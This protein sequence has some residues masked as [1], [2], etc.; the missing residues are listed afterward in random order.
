M[1]AIKDTKYI[2][3]DQEVAPPSKF[4]LAN[5]YHLGSAIRMSLG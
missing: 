1:S 3:Y 4:Q 2:S 5:Y